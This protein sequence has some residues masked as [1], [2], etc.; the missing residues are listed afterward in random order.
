MDYR[1]EKLQGN[2]PRDRQ[3][4]L[5]F[6]QLFDP[7]A[8]Q[9]AMKTPEPMSD[10]SHFGWLLEEWRVSLFAQPLGTREAVSLKR[11]KARWEQIGKH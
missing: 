8:E 4:M 9:L 2:L 11:L 5:E 7:F 3:S 1:L 10:L 6:Q